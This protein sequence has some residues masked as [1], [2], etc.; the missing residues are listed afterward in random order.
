MKNN[1]IN[2][3]QYEIMDRTSC[4]VNE[5]ADNIGNHPALTK[6]QNK[7]LEKALS[8]LNEVYQIAGDKF[9]TSVD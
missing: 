5:I 8:L 7:K 2:F 4:I 3:G 1:G 9:Y 6:K